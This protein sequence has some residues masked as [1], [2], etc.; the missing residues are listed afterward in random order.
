[1]TMYNWYHGTN[2]VPFDMIGMVSY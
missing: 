2:M 1:M